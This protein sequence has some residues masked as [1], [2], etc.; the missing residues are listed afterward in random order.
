[1]R[2]PCL[3]Y[4]CEQQVFSPGAELSLLLTDRACA[5]QVAIQ[6]MRA[7]DNHC[8]GSLNVMLTGVA[9]EQANGRHEGQKADEGDARG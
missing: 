3:H 6:E 7:G 8:A 9:F 5:A 2:C 1:M 4:G